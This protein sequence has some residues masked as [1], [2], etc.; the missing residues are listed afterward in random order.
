MNVAVIFPWAAGCPYRETARRWVEAQYA[1][2]HPDWPIVDGYSFREQFSRTRAIL[3][4]V[5]STD[6][7]MLVVADA[8]AWCDNLAETVAHAEQTGW[9]VPHRMV[10]RLSP[11]S[12]D[13]LIAGA[14]WRGLPLSTDNSQDRKPYVGNETGTLVVLTREAFD[15][16]PPDPRFV[17][18]GQEDTSWAS[19]LHTL[20]GGPWRGTADLVHL[21]HPPQRRLSRRVGTREGETLAG[22]YRAAK[23]KPDL[24]RR[25]VEQGRASGFQPS[26][27]NLH[28]HPSPGADGREPVP[29]P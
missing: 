4:G 19:A 10:H 9:A 22:R 26:R 21:W 13:K 18:W 5:A 27:P 25:L 29:Q 14:D 8:D 17:G 7:D 24:M 15:T 1:E 6:A 12:T 20:V 3:E 23:F 16:A 28:D 11:E 2:H